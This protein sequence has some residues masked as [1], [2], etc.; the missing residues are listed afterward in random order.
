MTVK[1]ACDEGIQRLATNLLSRLCQCYHPL[2]RNIR[3]RSGVMIR[4]ILWWEEV[5]Q[6][7]G[8]RS[9]RSAD[10]DQKWMPFHATWVLID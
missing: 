3:R 6:C 1:A 7:E 4:K 8:I 10:R 2:G 9:F 5:S